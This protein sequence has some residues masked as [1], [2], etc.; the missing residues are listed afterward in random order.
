MTPM[1]NALAKQFGD[2]FLLSRQ[3]RLLIFMY[4]INFTLHRIGVLD[5]EG[6]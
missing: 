6:V 1:Y 3:T 5:L 2:P 4:K